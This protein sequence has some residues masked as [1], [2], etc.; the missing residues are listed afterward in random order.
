VAHKTDIIAVSIMVIL[1]YNW[2]PL[3]SRF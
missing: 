3:I 1:L 2:W